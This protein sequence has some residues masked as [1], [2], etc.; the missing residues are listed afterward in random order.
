[1][2]YCAY[3][4]FIRLISGETTSTVILTSWIHTRIHNGQ[5]LKYNRLSNSSWRFTKTSLFNSK[6]N[7]KASYWCL[8]RL[9][10]PKTQLANFLTRVCES[11]THDLCVLPLQ[12]CKV[13]CDWFLSA[14]VTE[15]VLVARV[16]RRYFR[17][18][19]W[20]PEIRLRSQAMRSA[21]RTDIVRNVF[22]WGHIFILC[23]KTFRFIDT[24]NPQSIIII[25][26]LCYLQFPESCKGHDKRSSSRPSS[27]ESFAL[28]VFINFAMSSRTSDLPT[29]TRISSSFLQVVSVHSLKSPMVGLGL[30]S[31]WGIIFEN[32]SREA[33]VRQ[34]LPSSFWGL[35][36]LENSFCSSQVKSFTRGG[37]C[38]S[39]M[40]N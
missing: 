7:R 21:V 25:S 9:S 18:N 29:S 15:I 16:R 22:A 2:R 24:L 40:T 8:L 37:R 5:S 32:W 36:D 28:R 10:N 39:Y 38:W 6:T 26:L 4:T 31:S 30:C 3:S 34:S 20:Q 17:R 35:R 11:S 19:Q 33:T 27:L 14:D 23:G 13:K 1:M 12:I